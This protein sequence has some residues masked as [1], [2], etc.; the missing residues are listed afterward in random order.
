MAMNAERTDLVDVIL[1][2]QSSSI[3][4]EIFLKFYSLDSSF[5][6]FALKY[7]EKIDL[8]PLY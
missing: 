5:I 4:N 2:Y 3:N 7:A 6:E 8:Q 1:N